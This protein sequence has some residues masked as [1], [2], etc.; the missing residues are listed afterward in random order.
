MDFTP[1]QQA[2]IQ[3]LQNFKP[4]LTPKGCYAV[5]TTSELHHMRSGEFIELCQ[6]IIPEQDD[7]IMGY[8]MKKGSYLGDMFRKSLVQEIQKTYVTIAIRELK[9]KFP[10]FF[11]ISEIR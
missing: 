4:Q 3:S 5:M 2:I 9:E 7:M 1:E 10:S 6:Q 11:R 8:A